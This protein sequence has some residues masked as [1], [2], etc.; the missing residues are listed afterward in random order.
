LTYPVALLGGVHY[1][2]LARGFA[3]EP[4]VYMALILG[5]LATRL[6]VRRAIPA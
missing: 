4:L 2:W 1:I 6:P 3:I 5:L